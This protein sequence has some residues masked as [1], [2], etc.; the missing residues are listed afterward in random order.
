[1]NLKSSEGLY[2]SKENSIVKLP[3]INT[4]NSNSIY[5]K[6]KTNVNVAKS[7][8]FNEKNYKLFRSMDNE[9]NYDKKNRIML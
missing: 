3:I 6:G 7:S 8:N 2:L 9:R 5:D 4:N 1:M